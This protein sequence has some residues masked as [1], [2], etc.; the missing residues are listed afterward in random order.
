MLF[1]SFTQYKQTYEVA[2]QV[3]IEDSFDIHLSAVKKQER[4]FKSVLK[5]DKNFHVYIHG[6][7]DMIEKGYDEKSGKHFYKLFFEKEE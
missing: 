4:F 1:R 2:K 5:L 7:R 3:V 6:S